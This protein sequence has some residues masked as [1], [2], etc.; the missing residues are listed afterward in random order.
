ML[1]RISR[2][3]I[4]RCAGILEFPPKVREQV[5]QW[6]R[7][8]YASHILYHVEKRLAPIHKWKG[9]KEKQLA[10]YHQELNTAPAKIK[11]LE[12]GESYAIQFKEPNKWAYGVIRLPDEDGY[13]YYD[14]GQ[15]YAGGRF[16]WNKGGGY[17]DRFETA[18]RTVEGTIREEIQNLEKA[19]TPLGDENLVELMLLRK[20][21]LRYASRAVPLKDS[22]KHL[23]TV[24]LTDWKYLASIPNWQDIL[25]ANNNFKL[26]TV[27]LFPRPHPTRGGQWDARAMEMEVDAPDYIP[28]QVSGFHGALESLGET[29]DHEMRH[30]AQSVLSWVRGKED[31]HA[32]LPSKNLHLDKAEEDKLPRDPHSPSYPAHALRDV[33]FY[34]RLGDEVKKFLR[35][36]KDFPPY[37]RRWALRVWV[38]LPPGK[39]PI[40]PSEDKFGLRRIA[41]SDFFKMLKQHQPQK[42]RKAVKEFEKAVT[43]EVDFP[44]EPEDLDFLT[45]HRD[46]PTRINPF[47]MSP[48]QY[49]NARMAEVYG[50]SADYP[51]ATWDKLETDL[52]VKVKEEYR[53]FIGKL[54]VGQLLRHKQKVQRSGN[55]SYEYYLTPRWEAFNGKNTLEE[56]RH[57]SQGHTLFPEHPKLSR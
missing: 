25:L 53:R 10:K 7:E 18:L 37:T 19:Q 32:G 52:W 16:H 48:M 26:L 57:D 12:V 29:I 43:R 6:V 20:E 45:M 1:Q 33:E 44:D 41:P 9:Y 5:W 50:S 35:T 3:Y 23:F 13:A 51:R 15:S 8:R 49:W 47:G 31:Q 4:Q 27:V 30:L 54:S 11:A 42:W 21:C 28:T 39:S 22:D 55:Y 17:G 24:D 56:A 2:R 36:L 34:T 14:Y 38:D 40:D 46:E